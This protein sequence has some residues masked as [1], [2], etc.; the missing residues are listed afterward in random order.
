MREDHW[1]ILREVQADGKLRR[2][3]ER[4]EAIQEL[5]HSRAILQ[6]KNDEEWYALNPLVPAPP[7]DTPLP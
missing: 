1:P 5:L 7:D 2:T 6:Y 4:E 3:G